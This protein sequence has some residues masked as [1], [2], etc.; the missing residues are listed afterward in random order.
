M[1]AVETRQLI[2]YETAMKLTGLPRR[3]FYRRLGSVL[4]PIYVDSADRRKRWLDRNDLDKL[5]RTQAPERR[6]AQVA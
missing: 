5:A 6:G 3:T 1:E 2:S 4:I